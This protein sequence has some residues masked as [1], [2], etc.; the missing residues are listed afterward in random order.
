MDF[1]IWGS[2]VQLINAL[3]Q[4]EQLAHII[5]FR[6]LQA[7]LNDVERANSYRQPVEGPLRMIE[8]ILFSAAL[9]NP[10]LFSEQTV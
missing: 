7:L 9:R 4:S 2:L 6:S 10:K 5:D 1:Q 3:S 8:E